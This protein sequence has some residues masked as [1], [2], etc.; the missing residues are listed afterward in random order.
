M[1]VLIAG[2]TGGLGQRLAKVAISRGLLV[3]GFGRTL[4]KLAPDISSKLESFVETNSYYDIPALEKAVAGVDVVIN[5]YAPIPVLDLDGH[6]LL[7]RAAERAQIKIFI[8][9]SWS[10][11]WTNIKFGD[12]EHYNNHIAFEHQIAATSTIKPVYIFSGLFADL[13]FSSYGPGGFDT[14][15]ER[16][17][18]KYWGNGTA[19]KLP[20]STQD[21]AAEWTIDILLHGEGVQAGRGGCFKFSSGVTTIIE[22]AEVYESVCGTKVDLVSEGSTKDLEASLASLRKENRAGY[23]GYMVEAAAVVASKGLWENR[24]VTVLDQFRKPTSLGQYL[25]ETKR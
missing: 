16:P 17:K 15:G 18:M 14:S 6:L 23:F 3:R 1:L 8:A 9:S 12:F 10:R 5:A 19:D 25:Q 13:L 7:I 22:L 11:D 20:W 2:I 4:D 24:N 21:D